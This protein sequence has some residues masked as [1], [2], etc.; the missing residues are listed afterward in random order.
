MEL[1]KQIFDF[2]KQ[3]LVLGL[4]AFGLNANTLFNQY[5]LDDTVVLTGNSLVQQGVK[6]I[7][8]LFTSELFYGFDKKGTDLSEARY[9]PLALVLFAIEYQLF[10]KNPLVSHLIN[11]L[12]FVLL[13]ILLYQLL[14][15]Y[16]FHERNSYLAFVTCL[17]FAV[18][19]IH[20]EVIANV[21]SRDELIT[22]ILIICS[23]IALIRYDIK[24]SYLLLATGLSC[25]FLALLTR[26][27]AFTF[28]AVFPLLLYFF[29]KKELKASLLYILPLL[30]VFLMYLG[31]RVWLVPFQNSARLD[32][33]NSPFM[34]ASPGEA[35]ATKV[36]IL[37]KYLSLLFYPYPLSFDYGYNQI[38][39]VAL[40]SAPFIFSFIVLAG[41]AG[42]GIYTF[43]KRSFASFCIIYFFIH[44]SLVSNFVFDVGTTLADRFLFQASLAFCMAVAAIFIY[45]MR[46]NKLIPGVVLSLVIMLF[47]VKTYSRNLEWKNNET[48]FFKDVEST[49][50][51]VRANL[52]AAKQ[53]IIKARSEANPDVKHEYYNKVIFYDDRILAIYPHYKYIYEDLGIAYF[54]LRDYMKAAEFWMKAYALAPGDAE[55]KKRLDMLSDVLYNEGNRYFGLGQ[56]ENAIQSYRKSVE[57]NDANVD[58]WYNLGGSYFMQ[59]DTKDGIEAWMNVQRLSPGRA[60]DR[61]KFSK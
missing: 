28:V 30:I 31:L 45:G 20:T 42:Y 5:A 16:L 9:R 4:V 18:H 49:P 39:Y 26:E 17:L 48:L 2:K 36:Y 23:S 51:S 24:R 13:I 6:G 43:R 58:A 40:S 7:P 1:K 52:Y 57:L 14:H 47:C 33:L 59:N 27:S 38:P 37:F 21:K 61:T 60:L 32:I 22:F 10:G 34:N 15:R 53:Y 46:R 50:N 3:L 55:A 29:R 8:K 25:F 35:F 11:V 19:P 44:I 12:L 54:G 41:L 56:T